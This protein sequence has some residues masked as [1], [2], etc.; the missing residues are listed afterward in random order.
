VRRKP[1]YIFPRTNALATEIH[2]EIKKKTGN[3]NE[4][5]KDT[6]TQTKTKT[7]TDT[8]GRTTK[9]QTIIQTRN[10]T[11]K[12]DSKLYPP[13]KCFCKKYAIFFIIAKFVIYYIIRNPYNLALEKE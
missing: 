11:G 7:D 6:E 2:T 8:D 1:G 13:N 5:E 12:R 4:T 9:A 3:K 10:Q